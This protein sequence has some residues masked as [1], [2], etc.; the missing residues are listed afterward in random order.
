MNIG[1]GRIVYQDLV[2]INMACSDNSIM[3]NPEVKAAFE[4]AKK[5]GNKEIKVHNEMRSVW[6][7]KFEQVMSK[8]RIT[9]REPEDIAMLDRLEQE[10]NKHK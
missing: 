3:Q 6:K 5:G 1:G 4:N 7:A 10:V 9:L 8:A 2:K